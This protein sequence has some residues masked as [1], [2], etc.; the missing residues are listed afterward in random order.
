M[1]S[2]VLA[3]YQWV[4]IRPLRRLYIYGPSFMEYG[5][6]GGRSSSQICQS[7]T[8]YSEAFWQSN[9]SACEDII[10]TKFRAFHITVE[11]IVYFMLLYQLAKVTGLLCRILVCRQC[12][13]QNSPVIYLGELPQQRLQ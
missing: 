2:Q 13:R 8:T 3:I 10:E 4:I 5:F 9:V 7:I 6:W 1:S 12:Q 11:I